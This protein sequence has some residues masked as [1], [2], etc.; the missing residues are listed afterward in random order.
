MIL[1]VLQDFYRILSTL[2]SAK[3]I[4][5]ICDK[6]KGVAGSPEAETLPEEK[7]KW[8]K[9]YNQVPEMKHTNITRYDA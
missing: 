2:A 8:L 3:N 9:K 4:A 7:A 6:C 5:D 1:E